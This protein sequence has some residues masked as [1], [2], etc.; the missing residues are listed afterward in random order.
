MGPRSHNQPEIIVN[1]V[2]SNPTKTADNTQG[3]KV[4]QMW[5]DQL[6]RESLLKKTSG[7]PHTP[8]PQ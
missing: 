2:E 5:E 7:S 3:S 8:E 1:G 4:Q 6:L